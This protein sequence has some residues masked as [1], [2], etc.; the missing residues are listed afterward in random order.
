MNSKTSENK[1]TRKRYIRGELH[2]AREE[3]YTQLSNGA[4][5][6]PFTKRSARPNENGTI[7]NLL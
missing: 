2:E 3:E 1:V 4:L 6:A 7:E 5:A